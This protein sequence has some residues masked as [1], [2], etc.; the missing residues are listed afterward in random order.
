MKIIAIDLGDTRTGIA[1][2]DENEQLAFPVETILEKNEQMLLKKIA[3]KIKQLNAKLAVVG[4][5]INMDGSRGFRSL[6]CE[7]FAHKLKKITN[8]TIELYD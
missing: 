1:C 6:K 8:I 2:C 7:K 4:N 3:D 5:P